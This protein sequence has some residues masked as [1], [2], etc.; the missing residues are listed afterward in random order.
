MATEYLMSVNKFD[1]PKKYVDTEGKP[2]ATQTLITRLILLEPG[3]IQHH[4]HMGVGIVSKYRYMTTDELPA[5]RQ[6][7]QDQCQKYLPDLYDC[8][9][10]VSLYDQHTVRIMLTSNGLHYIADFD[11]NTLTLSELI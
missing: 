7:I 2:A 10:E 6:D 8:N 5:L 11:K 9:V 4:P 1:R 3:T